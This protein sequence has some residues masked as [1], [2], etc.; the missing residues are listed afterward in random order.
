MSNLYNIG[1]QMKL[2]GLK[3]AYQKESISMIWFSKKRLVYFGQLFSRAI[4]MLD[5]P[6]WLNVNFKRLCDQYNRVLIT[7][8]LLCKQK[9]LVVFPQSEI[10]DVKK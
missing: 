10:T 5:K 9:C 1:D 4:T 8:K 7:L 3:K 2:A 6:E